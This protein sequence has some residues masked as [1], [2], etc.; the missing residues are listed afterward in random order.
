MV[1]L[2]CGLKVIRSVTQGRRRARPKNYIDE[3]GRCQLWVVGDEGFALRYPYPE[4]RQ[5]PMDEAKPYACPTCAVEYKVVRVE[6]K[7]TVP[8]GRLT[9]RNCGGP[10]YA[11]EGR[12]ILKYFL[13]DASVR[14]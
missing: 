4:P 1:A 11:R 3:G 10:L 13:L 12:Y 8:E 5:C 2:S 6:A 9:C 7:T 14:T